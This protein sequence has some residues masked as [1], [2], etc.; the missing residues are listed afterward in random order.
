MVANAFPGRENVI[1]GGHQR[2]RTAQALGQENVPV[3]FIRATPA[4]ER[5]RPVL[6]V[7]VPRADDQDSIVACRLKDL[8]IA[9]DSIKP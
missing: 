7:K 4:Q 8:K 3:V 1:I 5:K 2:V 6:I 9:A